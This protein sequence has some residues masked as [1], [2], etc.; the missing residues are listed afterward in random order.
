VRA[1]T[2]AIIALVA[3]HPSAEVE[4]TMPVAN[5]QAYRTVGLKVHA[6][7]FAS[8]GQAI[9]LE[10][11]VIA[12]LQKACQFEQVGRAG[13][14][15]TDVVLDLNITRVGR[16]GDGLISNNNQ[17]M[18]DALLV[19]SDGQSGELLGSAQIKGKSSAALINNNNPELE[20]AEEVAKTIADMLGK[21]GCSG[22][23]VAKAEPPPPPPPPGPGSGS[24]GPTESDHDKAEAL[25]ESGKKKFR[26]ADL[27]GALADFQQANTIA[28]DARYEYNVCLAYEA[29]HEYEKAVASCR[30]ARGMSP[31]ADL[32]TKI[33]YRMDLLAQHKK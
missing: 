11:A 9:N 17:A 22:P 28:P 32:V 14:A 13:G 12:K 29:Q 20:V 15:P 1:E 5:L 10:Q 27:T 23:R 6:T 8:Q 18:L 31:N 3:C 16:G 26:T 7:A 2:F 24:A 4:R 30:E 19:L 21:S 25:N 33:D